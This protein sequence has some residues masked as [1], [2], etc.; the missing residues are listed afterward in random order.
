MTNA[1]K[2]ECREQSQGRAGKFSAAH[3]AAIARW[4]PALLMKGY[5]PV[6]KHLVIAFVRDFAYRP[7]GLSRLSLLLVGGDAGVHVFTSFYNF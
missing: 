1:G 4:V 2:T 5:F 7:S 3:G 6:C